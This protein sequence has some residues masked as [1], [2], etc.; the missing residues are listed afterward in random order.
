[1]SDLR[2]G[3]VLFTDF[4]AAQ[5]GRETG[6]RLERGVWRCTHGGDALAAQRSLLARWSELSGSFSGFARSPTAATATM[7]NPQTQNTIQPKC[8][9]VSSRDSPNSTPGLRSPREC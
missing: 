4:D 8:F 7:C 3:R 1:M 9:G 5:Y 6:E 2:S